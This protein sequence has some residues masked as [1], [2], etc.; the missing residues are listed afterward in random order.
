[1]LCGSLA[2]SA[3]LLPGV[4]G[5]Y[6]LQILGMYSSVISALAD[7]TGGIRSGTLNMDAL[8]LLGSLLIGIIAGLLLFS[9]L[10]NWMLQHARSVTIGALSGF[11]IGALGAVWPFWSHQF[12]WNP[13]KLDKG[14]LLHPLEPFLPSLNDPTTWAALAFTGL[15]FSLIISL[16]AIA[17]RLHRKTS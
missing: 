7:L 8:L 4:S 9:R 3:M 15:G 6:L 17:S 10:I 13:L 16:E 2:A 11:M 1:M 5:A 14:P 12:I